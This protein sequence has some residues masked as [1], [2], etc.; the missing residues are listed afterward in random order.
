MILLKE[1]HTSMPKS[2]SKTSNTL[3]KVKKITKVKHDT[4]L[5]EKKS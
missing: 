2:F 1:K 3:E 5:T 4:C